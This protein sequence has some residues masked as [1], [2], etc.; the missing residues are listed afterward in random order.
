MQ[1]TLVCVKGGGILHIRSLSPLEA[2]ASLILAAKIAKIAMTPNDEGSRCFLFFALASPTAA[3][4]E[5]THEYSIAFL[6]YAVFP[7]N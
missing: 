7:T 6:H 2:V 4:H 1:N 3:I 5:K